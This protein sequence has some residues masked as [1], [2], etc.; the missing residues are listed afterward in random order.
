MER[1]VDEVGKIARNVKG[2]LEVINKDVMLDL[3]QDFPDLFLLLCCWSSH[4]YLKSSCILMH[5]SSLQNLTN[6]QKPGCE[7]GTA[8]DRARMN[9]TKLAANKH[10]NLKCL[11]WIG[12]NVPHSR[13]TF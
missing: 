1:D 7:K 5:F 3:L 2:K 4:N 11:F 10:F 13:I 8:I 9:V 6:R 12:N